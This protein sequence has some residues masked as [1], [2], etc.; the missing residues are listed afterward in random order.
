MAEN[1]RS[2]G[3]GNLGLPDNPEQTPTPSRAATPGNDGSRPSSKASGFRAWAGRKYDKG[4]AKM[5]RGVQKAEKGVKSLFDR[6]KPEGERGA[7]GSAASG[8]GDNADVMGRDVE[9]AAGS[10]TGAVDTVVAKTAEVLSAPAEIGTAAKNEQ[11]ASPKTPIAS[12]VPKH[13]DKTATD[14][15]IEDT[16]AVIAT[17]MEPDTTGSVPQAHGAEIAPPSTPAS[18]LQETVS[19]VQ[20]RATFTSVATDDDDN[21]LQGPVLTS[22]ASAPAPA[23]EQVGAHN[24]Q[25]AVEG[26]GAPAPETAHMAM[27]E[28]TSAKNT[29]KLWALAKGSL[30]TALGIVAPLVPEPFKGPAEALLKV[31]DVVEKVDSNKEEVKILEHRCDL[32]G[33]SIVN[34]ISGKDTKFLSED[35]MDS[36]GRLVEGIQDTLKATIKEKSTGFAAYVLV[37][38]DVEVLKNANNKL[39]ELLQCFW[40]EN[41]IA[42]TIVLNSILANVQD[43]AEWMQGLSATLGKHFKNAALDRL[44]W[45]PGAAY[46]SQE[47]ADKVVSCFEGTRTTLLANVGRWMSGTISDGHRPLYV[48]DG[49]AGIG[50]STVALTVAQRA[51]G[52]NSLGAS[53]C[54]SRDQDDRKRSLGFVHTLAYQLARYDASY[55]DAVADAI[56]GNP[57]ALSKVLT[58]QFSLL[59]DKPLCPLLEQRK[60]PLVLVVD[61]L[62]ECVE[63]DASNVLK[64]IISSVCRLPNVKVLLTTRPELKLRSRYMGRPDANIFHLQEIED[65]IVEQDI[66]LYVN[67]SLSSDQMQEALGDSYHASWEPTPENKAKLAKLSGKLFIFA[68]TAI[69]FIL[70]EQYLNP[71]GQLSQILDLQSKN[72]SP[73][74]LLDDLYLNVLK[75]AKPAGE[76]KHW[77]SRFQK[78]VGAILAIQAPLS[79]LILENLLD[80]AGGEVKAALANLHSILAPLDF[81]T[82]PSC[83]SEFQIVE[84]EQHLELTKC[85]LKVMN[86]QLKFNI[87]Q[88]AIPSDDQYKDLDDLLKG[89]LTT[90]HISRELEYAV[91]Y[92]ANHLSKL[93][94]MDSDLIALLEE[95]LKKHLMHWLEALAYIK[96]LDIAYSALGTTLTIL[97]CQLWIMIMV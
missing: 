58:E 16:P 20:P 22:A 63:P 41:H 38:D 93:E 92:W 33:S 62:D 74:S 19:P 47:V 70:D 97:V 71:L 67:H 86:R 94:R 81:I 9:A 37:E 26:Q 79:A 7:E 75:S 44:K 89:G 72:T 15:G 45:V 10:G 39:D 12:L 27:K 3:G 52:I 59:V 1:T 82:G 8:S 91:C 55:G 25:E 21:P 50:K 24:M 46:D 14:H 29:S 11:T 83:P 40:I 90:D 23:A 88:V 87:C 84:K 80:Q 73:I 18:N 54:F 36:I 78:V 85:C 64:L 6:G 28:S 2:G 49:I 17:E 60:T 51:A 32:L 61:A 31:L 5:E 65:L 42:G 35:L 13:E 56:T 95:F 57:E 68:S 69:K 96:Q 76:A 77:L 30:K 66:S 43:Q 4:K 53:F 48:L 34:I